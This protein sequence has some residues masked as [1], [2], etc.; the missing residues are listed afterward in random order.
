M[1]NFE[2]TTPGDREIVMTRQFNAPRA[3][4]FEALTQPD[5]VRRWLLG[6]PGWSMPLCEI[7]LREGGSYRYGW[8]SDADGTE[9]GF[10]GT[11]Q[12]VVRPERIV[13][14]EFPTGDETSEGARVTWA[15]TERDGRTTLTST[16]VLPSREVRD[17]VLATGMADG[18][19]ASYDHLDE[20]LREKS[21][22]A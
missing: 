14:T 8:R 11:Y 3:L 4:V 16:M 2:V 21:A 18:V 13:T 20:L 6:P 5:L 12:E 9:F 17:A 1:T 15:L 19:A 7:D 10:H 22:S